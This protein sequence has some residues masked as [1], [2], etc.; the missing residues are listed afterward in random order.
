MD[1]S[2][3]S[4]RY[5]WVI[6]GL[7]CLIA[8]G[9]GYTG[10]MFS[11]MAAWIIPELNC[12][13][14]QFVTICM[15]SMLTAVFVSIPSGTLAD[16]YGVK[17]VILA[18][19]II[20]AA[21]VYMRMFAR[22][23]GTMFVVVF[24]GAFV[25]AVSVGAGIK[26][27][28]S[29]FGPKLNVASGI[30]LGAAAFGQALGYAIPAALSGTRANYI[31]GGTVLAVIAILWAAFAKN[32]PEGAPAP[33]SSGSVFK[34]IGR[35]ARNKYV[36]VVGLCVMLTY[37]A[38]STYA[39][40][41]PQAL[42]AEKQTSAVIAGIVT[43]IISYSTAVG[44]LL[45]PA[46][47]ARIFKRRRTT[48]LVIPI[49]TGAALMVSWSANGWLLCVLLAVDGFFLGCLQ[50]QFPSVVPVLPKMDSDC[51]ASAMGLVSTLQLAGSFFVPS[52]ILA[53]IFGTN[54]TP[55]FMVTGCIFVALAFVTCLIPDSGPARGARRES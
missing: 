38:L 33:E 12:T 22:S 44:N 11:P 40:Q 46:A 45:G 7:L 23:F 31:A 16:K 34:G 49:L 1:K 20:S 36:W 43:S 18:A 4:Q 24:F 53:P 52:Y 30:Y 51:T 29:W 32:L 5:R 14:Q 48:L 8:I 2:L 10:F 50:P 15:T 47:I 27:L 17:A 21:A 42:A 13:Q 39:N 28:S 55:M 25:N 19:I 6:L 35:A 54:Y 41:L 26:M 3:Y 9:R 37:G